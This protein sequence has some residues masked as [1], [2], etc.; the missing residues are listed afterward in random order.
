VRF[1][2]STPAA[3][4]RCL[5]HRRLPSAG[6]PPSRISSIALGRHAG[7][8]LSPPQHRPRRQLSCPAIPTEHPSNT[9]PTDPGAHALVPAVPLCPVLC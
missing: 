6:R 2:P 8:D 9:P 3:L 5:A 1:I 7:R 4:P